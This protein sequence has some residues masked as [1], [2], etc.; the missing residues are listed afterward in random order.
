MIRRPAP[1]VLLAFGAGLLT[2]LSHFWDP[3]GVVLLLGLGIVLTWQW[4]RDWSFWLTLIML[5][6]WPGGDTTSVAGSEGQVRGRWLAD[7]VVLGRPSG[8]LLVESF[9]RIGGVP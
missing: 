8:L 7:T 1:F 4:R 2:G 6:R 3:R 5:G 9:R